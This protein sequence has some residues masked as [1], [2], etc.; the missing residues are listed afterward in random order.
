MDLAKAAA[1]E[2]MEQNERLKQIRTQR[3]IEKELHQ[4]DPQPDQQS[5]VAADILGPIIADQIDAAKEAGKPL[6]IGQIAQAATI[7]NDPKSAPLMMMQGL[8]Q[9]QQKNNSF[10]EMRQSLELLKLMKETFGDEKVK[11]DP[12]ISKWV[13]MMSQRI[14]SP[15]QQGMTVDIMNMMTGFMKQN[16]DNM[17]KLVT[18][19]Q[20]ATQK[21]TRDPLELLLDYIPKIK[22]LQTNMG[23]GVS[24]SR[25][26]ALLEM[27]KIDLQKQQQDQ[28]FQLQLK[29]KDA[30]LQKANNDSTL[31]MII[32]FVKEVFGGIGKEISQTINKAVS[33]QLDH[34]QTPAFIQPPPPGSPS[35][36]Q[37][38]N[39]VGV[40]PGLVSFSPPPP[41]V[42]PP[43]PA[44][45]IPP[46]PAKP[47]EDEPGAGI[48]T[49]LK[50]LP[51]K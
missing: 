28:A 9:G 29:Q 44:D 51:R 24:P 18:R 32:G 22:D 12:A 33:T 40:G 38:L 35:P 11:S 23:A 19:L 46:P 6:D 37:L 43:P 47:S 2:S 45:Y 27:R 8:L 30:D 4:D 1:A 3:Q 15:Q 39:Q 17:D 10:D 25:E 5:N 31:G 50:I 21:Q 34:I 14:Q 13:E 36:Q 16:Q 48:M 20:D 41:P 49:S 26:S 42:N 7:L